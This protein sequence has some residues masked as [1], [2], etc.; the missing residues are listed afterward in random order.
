MFAKYMITALAGSAMLA[1]AALAQ[2]PSDSTTTSPPAAAS[3]SSTSVTA[4]GQWR[5]SKVVGLKIYNSS[6][7]NLGSVNDLL[8]D[9]E[10]RIASVVIGVGGF[11]GVGE[12]YVALPFDKVTWVNEP[13][14]SSTASS[15]GSGGAGGMGGGGMGSQPS[16]GTTTGSAATAPAAKTNPWYPDHGVISATKD[17]LKN[18]PEFKYEM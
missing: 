12:R 11:L 14:P 6:N 2:T 13:V 8:L 3:K 1:T 17:E 18:M 15:G 10:G 5:A 7:E 9:K 4:Q 16:S